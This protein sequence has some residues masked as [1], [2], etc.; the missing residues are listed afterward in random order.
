MNAICPLAQ[1]PVRSEPSDK[2]EMVT[3]ILFGETF[4]LLEER[5]NWLLIRMHHDNYEGWIDRKQS[6]PVSDDFIEKVKSGS[7]H[8]ITD[9]TAVCYNKSTSTYMLIGKG[10]KL[11]LATS[12]TFHIGNHAFTTIG[13]TK[14]IPKKF[15]ASKVAIVAMDYINTPYLWGGRSILGI[16]C[17]GFVQVV[18]YA[19]GMD[20]PRDAAQQ[21]AKGKVIDFID[22]TL[23]GDLAFFD[24]PTGEI[25]HVGIILESGKII[26]ASGHVKIDTIDHNGIFNS[27][28]NAYSHS[29]RII[30]RL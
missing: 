24:N 23:P 14:A 7:V 1:V 6:L 30:K 17:S 13:K 20:L 2:S 12:N 25:I 19:C 16:D 11:P 4:S 9:K 8:T 18:Y 27:D 21:A 22:E 15:S 5:G 28:L 3:Q 10:C 26:H 29:L